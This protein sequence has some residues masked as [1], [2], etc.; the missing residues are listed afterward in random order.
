MGCTGGHSYFSIGQL[1][2]QYGL[3]EN[4]MAAIMNTTV[5]KYQEKEQHP[6]ALTLYDCILLIQK[7]N[8][9]P[10]TLF[11]WKWKSQVFNLA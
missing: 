11:K 9:S 8:L 5:E 2:K 3:Q 6:E 4:E 1:R 10:D 7:F